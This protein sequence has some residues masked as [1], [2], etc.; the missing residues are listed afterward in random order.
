MPREDNTSDTR[1]ITPGTSA[2]APIRISKARHLDL[3]HSSEDRPWV[4]DDEP[5]A[6]PL[7]SLSGPSF[8]APIPPSTP[9]RVRNSS[10]AF[11]DATNVRPDRSSLTNANSPSSPRTAS[12]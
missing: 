9:Q 7:A 4:P 6:P 3:D 2:P 10:T 8:E 11:D 12:V 1:L 5:P